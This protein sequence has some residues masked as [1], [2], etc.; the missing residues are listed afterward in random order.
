M[1]PK[2]FLSLCLRAFYFMPHFG[3]FAHFISCHILDCSHILF[4]AT[5]WIVCIL[6]H[7]TLGRI[8]RAS[9]PGCADAFCF[10]R[11]PTCLVHSN[12][13]CFMRRQVRDPGALSRW[14]ILFHAAP[15]SFWSALMHFISC[16]GWLFRSALMHF[17]YAARPS[18]LHINWLP[19]GTL[20]TKA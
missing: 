12:S 11:R 20:S 14:C 15:G 4:H 3:L 5:F 9:S 17:F 8:A 13:V 1:P 19:R 10:M 16:G 7:D 2:L 6:F 18:L